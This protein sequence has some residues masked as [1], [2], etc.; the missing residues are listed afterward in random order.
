MRSKWTNKV[1]IVVGFLKADR[2]L[3]DK[4]YSRKLLVRDSEYGMLMPDE[5]YFLKSVIK[6][7]EIDDVE[8]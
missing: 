1:A 8:F 3:M 2:L 6:A 7:K 5:I 4:D